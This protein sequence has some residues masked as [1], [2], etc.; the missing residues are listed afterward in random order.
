[1][2]QIEACALIGS[3]SYI[4]PT[5]YLLRESHTP[6]R[7]SVMYADFPELRHECMR[8]QPPI[9]FKKID[10]FC[11]ILVFHKADLHTI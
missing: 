6:S 7:C 3:G 8:Q 11:Q 9:T 1:M 5:G 2:K 4:V 10:K